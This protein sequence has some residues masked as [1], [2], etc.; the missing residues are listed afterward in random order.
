MFWFQCT[1]LA[2]VNKFA[3]FYV[4][5]VLITMFTGALLIYK[6]SHTNPVNAFP[7]MLGSCQQCLSLKFPHQNPVWI[8]PHPYMCHI[9]FPCYSLFVLPS[10]ILWGVQIIKLLDYQFSTVHC[11][12]LPCRPKYLP[13][14][15]SQTPSF[16]VLPTVGETLFHTHIKQ[17]AKLFN[18][19]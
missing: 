8:S 19:F 5:Q 11:H 1:D 7:S 12:F 13:E 4:T 2:H 6:L 9:P 18:I 10:N 3:I 14:H 16:F 15:C 17:G